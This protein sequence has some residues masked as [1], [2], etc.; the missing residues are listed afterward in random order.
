MPFINSVRGSF[1][2]Q[3]RFNTVRGALGTSTGGSIT[4]SGI[5]RIHT[6]QYAQSGAAFVPSAAGTVEY[7]VVGGGAGGAQQHSG[8]GGAGGMRTGTLS[9]NSGQSY[10]ITVGNGGAFQ[11][12]IGSCSQHTTPAGNGGVS[13]FS[14][15]TSYGG[16]YPGCYNTFEAYGGPNGSGGGGKNISLPQ[17]AGG[18]GTAG[19]GYAGGSSTY[20]HVGGGGGGAGEVGTDGNYIA[21]VNTSYRSGGNGLQSSIS[22]TATYYAGGGGGGTHNVSASMTGGLGGGAIGGAGPSAGQ[23]G[24]GAATDG[25]GG[26]G[27]GNGECQ[28]NSSQ[29]FAPTRGGHGVVVVRYVL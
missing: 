27:G 14:S 20:N 16:G 21:T 5:Y 25:L 18:P 10:T 19:Q 17:G 9:V 7:L 13:T 29:N 23:R 26:G 11:P 12:N 15:I 8:G 22:G 4:T 1:G 24:V 3:G 6:F 28:P 2:S